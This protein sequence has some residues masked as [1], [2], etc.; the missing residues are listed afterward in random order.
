MAGRVILRLMTAVAIALVAPGWPIPAASQLAEQSRS[1]LTIH[2]GP[3]D[4]PGTAPVD[5]AI[6][7]VLQSPGESAVHYYAEYLE[8]EEFPSETALL[9]FRDYVREKF[10]GRRLDVVIA[11]ST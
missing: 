3:E 9:A 11:N 4:Y 7:E 6:R 10:A 8:A 2:W 5:A 1:V